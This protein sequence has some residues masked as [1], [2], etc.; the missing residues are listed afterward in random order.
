[1][2]DDEWWSSF[3]DYDSSESGEVEWSN[4]NDEEAKEQLEKQE[5][6]LQQARVLSFTFWKKENSPVGLT[7]IPS[8]EKLK[9]LRTLE[10]YQNENLGVFDEV[11]KLSL[12]QQLELN[13][14]GMKSFPKEVLSLT[15]LTRLS[16]NGN[17]NLNKVPSLTLLRDLTSLI[18]SE[19][20]LASLP[21][22]T[23]QLT[24][25]KTI[26]VSGNSFHNADLMKYTFEVDETEHFLSKEIAPYFQPLE[27]VRKKMLLLMLIR[28]KR[29]MECGDFGWI[30]VDLVKQMCLHMF[31]S[32][33][34][35][36]DENVEIAKS[37]VEV[38]EES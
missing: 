36:V 16:I 27:E 2:G 38:S 25:L 4:H 18:L 15:C 30:P 19:N 22:S 14:T 35:W 11:S 26:D 28:T 12:L 10:F 8:L 33:E 5:E 31:S 3:S 6:L 23:S 21:S 17:K 24:N 1:M 29:K 9:L 7:K 34:R 32:T 37:P 13:K 20:N